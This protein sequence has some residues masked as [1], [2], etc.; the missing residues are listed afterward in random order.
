MVAAPLPVVSSRDSSEEED[1]CPVCLEPL[2]FSFRLPGEKPHIVPECGHALHE[3]RALCYLLIVRARCIYHCAR[4]V[5][6]HS[7]LRWHQWFTSAL[8]FDRIIPTL[9]A[10]CFLH[11]MNAAF[12]IATAQR[13]AGVWSRT[14]A[15]ARGAGQVVR[16]ANLGVCG[17]CRRP[18][19]VGDGDGTK[20]NKLASLTGMGSV[21]DALF[22]G[23]DTPSSMRRAG[24][25]APVPKPYNPNEDDPIDHH[26]GSVRSGGSQDQGQGQYIV[27][28]SIQVRSEFATLTRTNDASQP[29][30]CIVVVELPGKRPSGHIP[31]AVM[32][33]PESFLQRGA[34]LAQSQGPHDM[35]SPSSSQSYGRG[36][37]DGLALPSAAAATAHGPPR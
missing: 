36:P 21:N 3:P 24:P 16:K 18:M 10:L 14:Q 25:G 29:L 19:K 22:P 7:F 23:R 8:C 26:A 31:G 5:K 17:V 15:R 34:K 27:S 32:P 11:T 1:E 12:R 35:H 33:N 37:F 13:R 2:S 20:S 6:S 9:F 30:T 28:P 4:R